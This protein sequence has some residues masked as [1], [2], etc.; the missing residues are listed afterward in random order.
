M[1]LDFGSN[2]VDPKAKSMA[3]E[4]ADLF[5]GVKTV[6]KLASGNGT[7]GD[8]L[9]VG[10]NAG[11]FFIPG[12]K[13]A[14]LSYKTLSKVL[15][16]SKR[17]ID[18][19]LTSF[20]AKKAAQRTIDGIKEVKDSRALGN[21]PVVNAVEDLRT[22]EANLKLGPGAT[23]D[24]LAEYQSLQGPA[25]VMKRNPD[26]KSK[27]VSF[28]TN[29]NDVPSV[30][31]SGKSIRNSDKSAD[32]ELNRS[33]NRGSPKEIK[34][35]QEIDKLNAKTPRE[36][37]KRSATGAQIDDVLLDK[38]TLEELLTLSGKELGRDEIGKVV[39]VLRRIAQ[40]E[41]DPSVSREIFKDIKDLKE[42]G[43][44]TNI[45]DRI[46]VEVSKLNRRADKLQGYIDDPASSAAI[47]Q[48][49]RIIPVRK[50][51]KKTGSVKQDWAKPR[52]YDVTNVKRTPSRTPDLPATSSVK[53]LKA[54]EKSLMNLL[55]K[56][57]NADKRKTLRGDLKET[58]TKIMNEEVRG[59]RNNLDKQIKNIPAAS[60]DVKSLTLKE[61]DQ[62]I[63]RLRTEHQRVSKFMGKTADAMKKEI[64]DRGRAVRARLD[65]SKKL[66]N[67]NAK[68]PD[69]IA[70]SK[71]KKNNTEGK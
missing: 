25:Q 35:A 45:V 11:I 33:L 34:T 26:L 28:V 30:D 52:S 44:S 57:S 54:D 12:A 61:L 22:T 48:T 60:K 37:A 8:A 42:N 13:L 14:Q 63:I 47:A 46:K 27:D 31:V 4:V 3:W 71:Q 41:K 49:Q 6:E 39:G 51:D 50:I 58:R 23:M 62:E 16:N 64:A 43:M 36:S 53:E 10:V 55:Q 18:N 38:D 56:E 9:T 2:V 59:L 24:D 69:E 21:N 19:D 29:K 20:A 5:F 17:V 67:P 32:A 40:K 68:S 70:R 65:E 66:A 1:D 7:W 15:F